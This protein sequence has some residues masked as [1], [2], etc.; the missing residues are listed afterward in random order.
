L[1]AVFWSL[2]AGSLGVVITFALFTNHAAA[3]W[4]ENLLQCNPL[5]LLLI[6]LIPA[7]R[8]WP[9]SARTVAF[10][11]L[12]L[13]VFGVVAKLTP[14]MWQSNGPIIAIALPVHGGVAWGIRRLANRVEQT[15]VES[16][17]NRKGAPIDT[18]A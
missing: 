5:S 18:P 10:T 12:G 11:V 15:N 8:Y 16:G 4:N 3:K 9:R 2:I 7:A 17:Q 1:F 13:C 6:V 14:W